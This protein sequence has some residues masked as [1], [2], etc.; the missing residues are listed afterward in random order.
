[1]PHFPFQRLQA[2]LAALISKTRAGDRL[3]PNLIFQNNLAFHTLHYARPCAR[4]K[5]RD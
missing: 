1:M 4:L 3:P 2:D 5:P